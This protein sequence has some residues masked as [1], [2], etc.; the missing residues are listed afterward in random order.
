MLKNSQQKYKLLHVKK[1]KNA[2][3]IFYILQIST[4][5]I[6]SSKSGR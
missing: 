5:I 6:H 3:N 2:Y 4:L 1:K